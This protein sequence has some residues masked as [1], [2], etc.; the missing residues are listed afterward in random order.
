MFPDHVGWLA[1]IWLAALMATCVQRSRL[2]WR[3][4]R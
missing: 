1:W 2:A 4:L 3:V